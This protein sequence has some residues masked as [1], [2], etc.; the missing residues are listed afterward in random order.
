MPTPDELRAE[1][2]VARDEM[3]TALAGATDS[4]TTQAEDG[5]SPKEIAA[6][7]SGAE[8]GFATMVCEACGYPGP[9][10]PFDM[11][12]AGPGAYAPALVQDSLASALETFDQAVDLADAKVRQI[13]AHELEQK[14]AV[15]A[16]GDVGN[17]LAFWPTHLRDHA[18]QIRATSGTS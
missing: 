13:Q 18:A 15:E 1:I 7:A 16:L 5:W 11:E 4:W 2:A 17:V 12:G 10:S 14:V 3:R 9:E 6:H 8:I